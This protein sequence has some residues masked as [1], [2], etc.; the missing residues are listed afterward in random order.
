[1]AVRFG[2][3]IFTYEFV[4]EAAGIV[5]DENSDSDKEEEMKVKKSSDLAVHSQEKL[6]ELLAQALEEENYEKAANIR[7][8]INRRT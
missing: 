2:C 5:L 1:M 6:T 3:P 8:E 4:L 7:D